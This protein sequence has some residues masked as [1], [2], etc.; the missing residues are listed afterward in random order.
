MQLAQLKKAGI[1]GNYMI[2][3]FWQHGEPA[4]ILL[5][6]LEKI[7][8][9][10]IGAVCVESRPHPDFAGP[11]WWR[12]LD[13]I[14]EACRE[15]GMEVWVL[16][17]ARF[18]TGYANGAAK[19]SPHRKLFLKEKHVDIP[20]P[21]QGVSILTEI[22]EGDGRSCE[23]DRVIAV[24]AARR[25]PGKTA[26]HSTH[27]NLH[28][29]P[30]EEVVDLTPL[31]R[32][33]VIYWDVPEGLWR[34]FIMA[35]SRSSGN[36]W[37]DRYLNPLEREGTQILIDA[38]YQPHYQ[39]YRA[40][41]GRTFRGFFSD[42]PQFGSGYGYHAMP[43]VYPFLALP[44]QPGLPA[45][46][47]AAL[48]EDSRRYWPGIWYDIGPDT[49]RIRY[50][51]MDAVSRLYGEN[52]TGVIG[53]WCRAHGVEY[54]GHVIE[55]NNAHARLGAGAGHYFRALWGQDY[56]GID[57]VLH[58]VIPGI[59]GQSHAQSARMF[60][61]DDDF[62]Y[63]LLAQL[64]V[65]LAQLDPKKRGRAMCEIFGAFGWQE[66]LQQMKW[67]ADFFLS[68][69]INC[70]VPHAF[71]PKEFPDPDSA[72][73]FYAR[74]HNPQYRYFHKLMGYMNRCCELIGGGRTLA[75]AAVLYHAEAEWSGRDYMK[76]QQPLKLLNQSQIEAAV[77]PAD[78]LGEALVENGELSVNGNRYGAL[79]VPYAQALPAEI[80]RRLAGLAAEG[81]TVLFAD[82]FPEAS[83]T[84]HLEDPREQLA[85]AGCRALPLEALPGALSHLRA[86]T[87]P[88]PQPELKLYPY[89]GADG[90][91][92][93]LLFNEDIHAAI[94]TTLTFTEGRAPV[95]YDAMENRVLAA[96]ASRQGDHV[97]VQVHME[98][99]EAAILVFGDSPPE[100]EVPWTGTS[101]AFP[102]EGPWQVSS[103]TAEQYPDFAPE[104]AVTGPGNLNRPDGLP[105][106]SGT[107]RYETGFDWQGAASA[108]LDLGEVGE[109]AE[110]WLNGDPCGVRIAPPYRWEVSPRSG[111]NTLR[112]E[113]TNTLVY[114]L[115]DRQSGFQA[116]RPW[117]LIGP[118]RMWL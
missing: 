13:L 36:D 84:A 40:D 101:S 43:G 15:K 39:R 82:G 74:G 107:L 106:F 66:G 1:G 29:A 71:S 59:K 53:D 35:E 11:G 63:Y 103:A 100:A 90:E 76:S 72:P 34:V 27:I 88:E 49:K 95:W 28:P 86:A 96:E 50:A 4:P 102:L 64:A 58:G 16:D 52:F 56:A 108:V 12:D 30:V 8:A 31:I 21:Q 62:Y 54:M 116:I 38:V 81:A 23:E 98:P 6:E 87:T 85:A 7:H 60:E 89:R 17:D 61:A 118:V 78:L 79:V 18:P 99:C 73:H 91:G 77:L 111:R 92:V 70:F 67:Y 65:S 45:L 115:H 48:G 47:D 3:F 10:G 9:A 110:V 26:D 55:E 69:G 32:D 46:L 114:Q 19:D 83:S 80:L 109:T 41:F 93:Y 20:G 97:T 5:E 113:V 44:W 37:Q 25:I 105:R 94:D 22:P 42:E 75:R 112:V 104:P 51:Y 57:L 68:R 14:M 2:P 33:D 24:V 117:G